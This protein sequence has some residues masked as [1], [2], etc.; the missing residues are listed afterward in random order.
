[1][2]FIAILLASIASLPMMPFNR[3]APKGAQWTDEAAAGATGAAEKFLSSKQPSSVPNIQHQSLGVSTGDT[4][5]MMI[6]NLA[7]AT[8]P[9]KDSKRAAQLPLHDDVLFPT[10]PETVSV[11]MD[12]DDDFKP[13]SLS[14]G[15]MNIDYDSKPSSLSSGP[16]DID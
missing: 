15:P 1:M 16:M 6:G 2:K 14:S 3:V 11:N 4:P 13:S 10:L 7:Q 5:S 12:I 8:L 9:G